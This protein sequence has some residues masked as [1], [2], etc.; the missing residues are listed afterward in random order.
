M[1]ANNFI[2]I[3]IVSNKFKLANTLENAHDIVNIINASPCAFNLF[4]EL[5]L[6]GYTLG[7]KIYDDKLLSDCEDA[8]DYILKNVKTNSINFIG[9]PLKVDEIYYNV[10]LVFQKNKILGLVP[11]TYIPNYKEFDEGAYYKSGLYNKKDSIKLLD[12]DVPFGYLL[13]RDEIN[14]VSFAVEI[15]EDMWVNLSPSTFY[16]NMGANIIFNLSATTSIIAKEEIRR[17]VLKDISRRNNVAYIYA[18][19]GLNENITQAV[20]QNCLMAYSCGREILYEVKY[21]KE[22]INQMVGLDLNKLR[23]EATIRQYDLPKQ[24]F[25]IFDIKTIQVELEKTNLYYFHQSILQTSKDIDEIINLFKIALESKFKNKTINVRRTNLEHLSFL[26][27]IT[28]NYVLQDEK[29]DGG[30]LNLLCQHEILTASNLDERDYYIFANLPV[31]L[32][33]REF[34][35]QDFILYRILDCRDDYE[36]IKFLISYLGYG[37][38]DLDSYIETI[39]N[40]FKRLET[41]NLG[42]RVYDYSII[43]HN[44]LKV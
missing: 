4:P 26:D 11:K 17:A 5:S 1:F 40:N 28:T 27:K 7:E 3:N 32:I 33:T 44:N 12:Q 14:D 37:D 2:D 20:F 39:K 19:S 42:V 10:A 35:I 34:S 18:S 22:T 24:S 16:A 31:S 36:Q 9:M 15:C 29:Y 23:F 25:D 30:C 38:F 13:F 21:T 8:L 6:T 43:D 41:L